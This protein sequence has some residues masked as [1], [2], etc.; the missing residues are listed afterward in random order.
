MKINVYTENSRIW[1]SWLKFFKTCRKKET[2]EVGT[3]DF[4]L[5]ILLIINTK[6]EMWQN[7]DRTVTF[8]PCF[9]VIK[10]KRLRIH[11]LTLWT[12]NLNGRALDRIKCRWKDTVK[13]ELEGIVQKVWTEIKLLW[14]QGSEADHFEPG[15]YPLGEFI[16]QLSDC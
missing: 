15:N 4:T 14:I 8:T 3:S 13:M 7:Y 2:L 6:L 9:T 16:E 11:C 12:E 5:L 1:R 10:Q